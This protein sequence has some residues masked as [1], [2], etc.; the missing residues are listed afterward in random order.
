MK[1]SGKTLQGVKTSINTPAK[2]VGKKP[3]AYYEIARQLIA[4][5]HDT[6]NLTQDINE[7]A[8]SM[9]KSGAPDVA[10]SLATKAIMAK[11]YISSVQ[12]KMSMV[13][14]PF[15]GLK[16]SING[17]Q[18]G[19]YARAIEGATDPLSLINDIATNSVSSAKVKAVA[20]VYPQLH[21]KINEHII[22]TA[23]EHKGGTISYQTRLNVAKISGGGNEYTTGKAFQNSM[24]RAFQKQPTKQ[25][26][27]MKPVN[28]SD[29]LFT[30]TQKR[31]K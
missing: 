1:N 7:A 25:N 12:P 17:A 15:S 28:L 10:D 21:N 23:M 20:A 8:N 4:N 18:V 24:Q 6:E 11:Q 31:G 29:N 2:L 9:R 19:E 16:P 27:L 26:S 22:H 14:S 5:Q 13:N 3:A 30:D